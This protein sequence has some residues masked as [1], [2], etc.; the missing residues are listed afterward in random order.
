MRNV[1]CGV[2]V[3]AVAATRVLSHEIISRTANRA[4]IVERLGPSIAEQCSQSS[5]KT[6]TDLGSKAVIVCNAVILQ[7]LNSGGAVLRVRETG[8]NRRS[9]GKRLRRVDQV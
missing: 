4:S 1:E 3:V 6:L 8:D 2:T 7:E 5:S 9:A